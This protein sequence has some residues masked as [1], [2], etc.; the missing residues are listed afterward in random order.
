MY[1]T[2]TTAIRKYIRAPYV[3][4]DDHRTTNPHTF[5]LNYVSNK[6]VRSWKWAPPDT[7]EDERNFRGMVP[8]WL[9]TP[10]D[11]IRL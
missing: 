10:S 4:R 11:G 2:T 6:K 9:H 1:M 7:D 5:P 3:L 8:F